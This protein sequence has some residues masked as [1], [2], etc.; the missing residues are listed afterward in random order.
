LIKNY[1]IKTKIGLPLNWW[2]DQICSKARL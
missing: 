1:N 2:S